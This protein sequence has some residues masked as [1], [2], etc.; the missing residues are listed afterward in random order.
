MRLHMPFLITLVCLLSFFSLSAQTITVLDKSNNQPVEGV[1]ITGSGSPTTVLTNAKG[2]ADISRLTRSDTIKFFHISY[3]FIDLTRNAI[4]SINNIIMLAPKLFNLGEILVQGKN[5]NKLKNPREISVVSPREFFRDNDI[6]LSQTLNTVPGV[7][8][9]TMS[10]NAE[11]HILLRGIGAKS[12]F[13][14]R[15]VKIYYNGIPL[16]DADGTTSLNDIDF[17]A[18]GSI[19]IFKGPSS[20]IYGPLTGGAVSFFTKKARFEEL[21]LNHYAIFGSYGLFRSNNNYRAGTEN[22][23]MFVNYGYQNDNGYREHSSSKRNY[24]TLS[25]DFS[26]SDHQSVSFLTLVNTVDDKFP[27]EV[28][29]ITYAN[30]PKAANPVYTQKDIGLNQKSFLTGITHTY[31][32]TKEFQN[33]SSVFTGYNFSISPEEPYINRTSASKIGGRTVFSWSSDI[34]SLPANLIL[35]AEMI[36]NYDLE[37]H[38]DYTAAFTTGNINFDREYDLVSYVAFLQANLD[39]TP[40]VSLTGG[41]RLSGGNY[42]IYDFLPLN[43]VDY[44]GVRNNKPFVTP[45][46][47]L[48]DNVDENTQLY[49]LVSTGYSAPTVSEI[50]LP[51]GDINNN[52]KPESNI[53]YEIGGKGNLPGNKLSYSG[54]LYYMKIVDS[55]IPQVING[56]TYNVNAGKSDNMGFEAALSYNNLLNNSSGF[57]RS[58]RPFA[59]YTFTSFKYK[60]YI[61]GTNDYAGNKYP[62]ISPNVVSAGFDLGLTSGFYLYGTYF[63]FDKRFLNDANSSTID[64]YSLLNAKF[65]WRQRLLNYFT[66]QIYSGMDNILNTHYSEVVA[67]NQIAAPGTLPDY[68]NASPARNFFAAINIEFHFDK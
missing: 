24:F 67:V 12:R 62:G 19:Q 48:T 60:E 45:V 35:G 25:G 57:F 50:L 22:G 16:T 28:D 8:M 66:L 65:G 29:S 23:N 47:S 3:Q 1:V 5:E 68:F 2:I 64:A 40:S 34:A 17:S 13:N 15:D 30:S 49:A 53:N 27:G 54:A 44:S 33:I 31:N 58:L 41:F 4:A 32:F 7:K 61:N 39:L 46:I 37:K 42:T 14:L 26:I 18:F 59:S 43:N 38:Y 36:R 9:E 6:F 51:N 63:Y 20:I 10:T 55:Y 52:L 11:S 56:I 21:D